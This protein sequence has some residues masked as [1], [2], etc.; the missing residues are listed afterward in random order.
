[1]KEK[2]L[3]QLVPVFGYWKKL[4]GS[5]HFPSNVSVENQDTIMIFIN[6]E[7][8][9]AKEMTLAINR[10]LDTV[11]QLLRKPG[12]LSE[13]QTNLLQSLLRDE[14]PQRYLIY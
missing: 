12:V 8:N 3:N 9:F 4:T 7:L 1:V 5:S 6:D 10:D 11:D 14:V 13:D 2:A